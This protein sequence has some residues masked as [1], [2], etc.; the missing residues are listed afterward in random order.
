MSV[1]GGILIAPSLTEGL[2]AGSAEG[3]VP[4]DPSGFRIGGVEAVF[5]Y[6][7][8]RMNV[9]D[10]WDTYIINRVTGL[11]DADV[12]DSREN[13]PGYDGET[14][15]EANY[16]G[17][18]IVLSGYIRAY[19]FFKMRDMEKALRRAFADLKVEDPLTIKLGVAE[20]DLVVF[21]KKVAK[22][23]IPEEQTGFDYKRNFQITLRSSDHRIHSY[24]RYLV[25]KFVATEPIFSVPNYGTTD[26]HAEFQFVGP[27]TD[28]E[29]VVR[30]GD[31]WQRM[32][33]L[34]GGTTIPAGETWA[35]IPAK[36]S[37][38]RLSD[39]ANR[40]GYI[41][42]DSEELVLRPY[43]PE[44]QIE[45]TGTGMNA[46]SLVSIFYRHAFL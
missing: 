37:F 24:R 23:D 9:R 46:S 5:E 45:V 20:R 34:K 36:N 32:F 40:W 39:G 12:R 35:Y 10:W 7:G 41:A 38:R 13:N 44:N 2:G 1:V 22:L 16:G 19:S 30:H 15:G 43:D 3:P 4:A 28:L 17:R 26:A 11:D 8:L 29:V 27:I 33:K 42:D 18:T 6:R 21:C 14:P 25:Q 31:G